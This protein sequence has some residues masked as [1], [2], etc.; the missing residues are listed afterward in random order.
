MP[1]GNAGVLYHLLAGVDQQRHKAV[2]GGKDGVVTSLDV[3]RHR[4]RAKRGRELH[5][6]LQRHDLVFGC[7]DHCCW[8]GEFAQPWSRIK[9]AD[10]ATG[11]QSANECVLRCK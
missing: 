11:F 7:H 8:H 1:S 4:R 5:L 3:V 10:F 2:L 9:R 6:A